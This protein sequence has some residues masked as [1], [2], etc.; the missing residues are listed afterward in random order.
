MGRGLAILRGWAAQVGPARR[1]NLLA[2]FL[3]LSRCEGQSGE[4]SRVC[5]KCTI[6]NHGKSHSLSPLPPHPQGPRPIVGSEGCAADAGK[7]RR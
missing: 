4:V 2:F 7:A 1:D 3:A 5:R 6:P